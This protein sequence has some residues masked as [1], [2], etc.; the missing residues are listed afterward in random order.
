[1]AVLTPLLVLAPYPLTTASAIVTLEPQSTPDGL[2]NE[3]LG[4]QDMPADLLGQ[5]ERDSS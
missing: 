1:M 5:K 4:M 2:N 3:E